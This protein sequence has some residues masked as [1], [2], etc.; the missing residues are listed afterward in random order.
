MALD[1]KYLQV[2]LRFP[3]DAA[4]FFW[5]P[6]FYR[7]GCGCC[8]R[9]SSHPVYSGL[10]VV[11]QTLTFPAGQAT[12]TALNEYITAKLNDQAIVLQQTR[13]RKE[14]HLGSSCGGG[15]CGCGGG[16]S[17]QAPG[18]KGGNPKKTVKAKGGPKGGAP[19]GGGGAG[20]AE[21]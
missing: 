3:A 15:Y 14:V 6:R 4:G 13:L 5:H 7:R 20:A 2:L 10:E 18:G 16:A 19:G 11:G 8:C 9:C 17:D 12:T 1:G 21:P